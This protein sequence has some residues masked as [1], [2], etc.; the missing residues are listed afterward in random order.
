MKMPV[1]SDA[2]VSRLSALQSRIKPRLGRLLAIASDGCTATA[3]VVR[4]VDGARLEIEAVAT[5]RALKI[6]AVAEELLAGLRAQD[7]GVPKQAIVLTAGMM[8][9]VLE[10]PVAANKPLSAGQMLEM[11]RWELEPLFAQQI[12][13]W[14]TGSLLFGRGYLSDA[15][16]L[17]LLEAHQAVQSASRAQGGRLAAARIGELAI[18]KG[19][20]SRE[21]VEE[22]LAL[23]EELQM[24]DADMLIGW[25]GEA[26]GLAPGAGQSAWLCAAIAPA[27]RTRWVDALERLGLRLLWLYPLAGA[28]APLAA[29]SQLPAG[30]E[31]HRLLGLGYRLKDG[32]LAAMNYRQFTAKALSA[33]EALALIS[34]LLRPDDRQLGVYPGGGWETSVAGQLHADLKRD[35]ATLDKQVLT[36]PEDCAASPA[37]LGALAG[38]AAHA[39]GLAPSASAVHLPGSPLPPPLYRRPLVWAGAS[40]ALVLIAMGGFELS[41]FADRRALTAEQQELY[42]RQNALDEAKIEVERAVNADAEARKELASAQEELASLDLQKRFYERIL[43]QRGPFMESLLEALIERVN[44][45]LL[46]ESVAETG[47]QQVEVQGFSL[48]AEAVY[49]YARAVAKA[50]DAFGVKLGDLN[51]GEAQGPLDL[52]GY[53]FSFLLSRDGNGHGE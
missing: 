10:L 12:G 27:M 7:V 34:P 19:Y 32:A 15:H 46:L 11:I 35:I 6:E 37:M 48:N 44:D 2:I 43:G 47:W 29:L 42:R 41:Q 16:R 14:F 1:L 28:S 30:L 36:W 25:H 26:V 53:R 8:P 50:L 49:R 21:Q 9:A 4:A 33:S 45:E 31:L 18:E 17:A 23:Q 3:A 20:V 51:T 52:M 39:L 5:S 24:T 13:L 22:C 38:G 40:A